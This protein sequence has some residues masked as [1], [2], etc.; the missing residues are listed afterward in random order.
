MLLDLKIFQ[1]IIP[2]KILLNDKTPEFSWIVPQDAVSQSAYQILV[3]SSKT[4]IDNNIGD[5]WN[6]NQVQ[7]NKFSNVTFQGKELK[8]DIEYFWKVRIWDTHNRTGDYS[9][10]QSFR[11][12]EINR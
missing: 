11:V 6:S 8:S 7:G 4:N 12:G 10:T 1:I 9:E 2:S 5:I 3:A